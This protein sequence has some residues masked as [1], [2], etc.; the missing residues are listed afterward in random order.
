[1]FGPQGSHYRSFAAYSGQQKPGIV[2]FPE[3]FYEHTKRGWV[4]QHSGQTLA[5]LEAPS[6]FD[7][8]HC[9]SMSFW[10]ELGHPS[11]ICLE[12]L[13]NTSSDTLSNIRRTCLIRLVHKKDAL[14]EFHR[15]HQHWLTSVNLVFEKLSLYS[16]SP[17]FNV[18]IDCILP[19]FLGCF[20]AMISLFPRDRHAMYSSPLQGV[21]LVLT[22]YLRDSNPDD[23]NKLLSSSQLSAIGVI[24]ST[25]SLA[26]GHVFIFFRQCFHEL[27]FFLE[28]PELF[29]PSKSSFVPSFVEY[30]IERIYRELICFCD[31]SILPVLKDQSSFCCSRSIDAFLSICNSSRDISTAL[32]SLASALGVV[33]H[34]HHAVHLWDSEN[35]NSDSMSVKLWKI[36]DSL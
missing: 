31:A 13:T 24:L 19:S 22:Q 23:S 30:V 21:C 4:I 27:T 16:I 9:L 8:K 25:F 20:S 29:D 11:N 26:S 5:F 1:L 6:N 10:K 3:L 36:K 17:I 12:L 32:L 7:L 18:Q 34:C 15:L 14:D 33:A 2:S 35:A 28:I